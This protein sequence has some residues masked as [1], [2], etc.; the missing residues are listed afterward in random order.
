MA[1][2]SIHQGFSQHQGDCAT[3]VWLK[4]KETDHHNYFKRILFYRIPSFSH[5]FPLISTSFQLF[6]IVGHMSS[7]FRAPL[8]GPLGYWSCQ[9]RAPTSGSTRW[10][11]LTLCDR[12]PHPLIFRI[13][14][15]NGGKPNTVTNK[16]L[17]VH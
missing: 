5:A 2:S 1:I 4:Y 17:V 6:G 14:Q 10:P 3:N 12:G 16:F 9:S 15:K 7:P 13:A 11:F 8:S